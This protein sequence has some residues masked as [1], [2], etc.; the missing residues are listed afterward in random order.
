M[1]VYMYS[2]L[3]AAPHSVNELTAT[4]SRRSIFFVDICGTFV[5]INRG[6]LAL[7]LLP[8]GYQTLDSSGMRGYA[9]SD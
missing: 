4:Y 3:Y 7:G 9:I 8:V 6:R 5:I 1:A 2:G